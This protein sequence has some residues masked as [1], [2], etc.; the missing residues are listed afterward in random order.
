MESTEIEAAKSRLGEICVALGQITPEQLAEVLGQQRQTGQRFG[1]ILRDRGLVSARDIAEAMATQLGVP[2]HD[3]EVAAPDPAVTAV[4]PAQAALTFVMLPVSRKGDVLRL[5]MLNPADTEALEV[6]ARL[7]G[8][9]P[10]P[11]L[12]EGAALR[13]TLNLIYGSDDAGQDGTAL[14]L[15]ALF[16]GAFGDDNDYAAAGAMAATGSAMSPV[17]SAIEVL[18]AAPVGDALVIAARDMLSTLLEEAIQI[19]ATAVSVE[20]QGG[21]A[22][23]S[24]RLPRRQQRRAMLRSAHALP[25]PAHTALIA[26]IKRQANLEVGERRRAQRGWLGPV[27][28]P[29]LPPLDTRVALLPELHGER[30]TLQLLRRDPV[31]PELLDRFN[32]SPAQRELLAALLSRRG[33][34]ILVTGQNWQE[35]LYS[36]VTVLSQDEGANARTVVTCELAVRYE[37]PHTSQCVVE[38]MESSPEAMAIAVANAVDALQGQDP[39][40]LMVNASA[41]HPR[42]AAAVCRVSA[43]APASSPLILVGMSAAGDSLDA[44]GAAA[45]LKQAVGAEAAASALLGVF[46]ERRLRRLC[47]SCRAMEEADELTAARLGMR[48]GDPIYRAVGCSRCENSGYLGEFD[49]QEVLTCDGGFARLLRENVDAWTLRHYAARMGMVPLKETAVAR[50]RAG[51]TSAAEVMAQGI[52]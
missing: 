33:G 37:I 9:T 1:D 18:A 31:A 13:R 20:P 44:A 7:T 3:L 41:A 48:V 34:L 42:I 29:G 28:E 6:A 39:D 35:M 23:I 32:L 43:V 17:Q 16:P 46:T 30:I 2:F 25:R 40:V 19:G 5:A 49:V 26:E 11:A 21:H 14:L 36:L 27:T 12:G 50:V 15:S 45:A 24:Y 22:L 47:L 52:V 10:E 51:L 38:P 4:L 8:L